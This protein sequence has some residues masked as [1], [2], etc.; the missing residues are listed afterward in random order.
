MTKGCV[1][2]FINN[3]YML[4]ALV[5]ASQARRLT[6][7]PLADVWIVCLDRP[8]P[9]APALDAAAA[10]AGVVIHY[11]DPAAIDGLHIMFARFFAH[12]LV[13]ERYERIVYIDGDTQIGGALDPLFTVKIPQGRF[14]ACRDPGALF[15]KLSPGRAAA[16]D[17]H[18][19]RIGY[20]GPREDYVNSGVM[21]ME[22]QSWPSLAD[23]C[24]E[25]TRRVGQ[26]L[27]HP[28]QDVLNLAVGA[29]CLRISNRWNF[30]GFLIGSKAEAATAPRI[31]HFMSNPRP[32][33][34]A[35]A[36]WGR[37]WLDPYDAFLRDHPALAA[38]TPD[39]PL[40]PTLRYHLQQTIKMATEYGPVGR[41]QET[42]PELDV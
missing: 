24:L 32:W 14:L 10:K 34:Y 3:A 7:P 27:F 18:Y 4:P 35:V 41:L 25:M 26:S 20:A 38:L 8:G 22:R 1:V 12:R 40:R 15:A 23:A 36:P 13:P 19:A 30:P 2:Y 5:S 42:A 17:A 6:D 31:Y 9:Q 33:S 29:K 28:D 11:E 21:V 39:R 16:L 37:A